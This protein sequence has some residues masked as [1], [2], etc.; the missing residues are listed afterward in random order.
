MAQIR[1]RVLI[2]A[3][4]FAVLIPALLQG[5]KFYPDD[6]IRRLPDPLPV[7][8][9]HNRDLDE[10]VDFFLQSAHWTPPPPT[11]AGE[12][13]T[14]GEVPDSGGSQTGMRIDTLTRDELQRGAGNR[15]EPVPPFTVLGG[16]RKA[17]LQG[18]ECGILRAGC[19]SSNRIHV[20]TRN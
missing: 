4:S 3:V 13:N 10:V 20:P 6:P 5:Q 9:P 11:P 16:K 8:E 7:R 14:L 19:I 17:Y 2:F 1:Q 18:F 12:V 15:N